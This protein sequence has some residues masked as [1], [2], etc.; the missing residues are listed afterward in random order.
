MRYKGELQIID[1]HSHILP[2]LD[3]G[4]KN[5]EQSKKMLDIA[6][7]QNIH[8]IIATPHFMPEHKNPSKEKVLEKLTK[9]QEYSDRQGYGITL[10]PG[11]EIYYHEEVPDLLEEGKIITLANS[12]YVLVEFSPMDD[13][14]YIR[15]SLA[16][17]QNVGFKPIIAHVERYENICRKPFNKLKEL[18]DMGVM[19][20]V[21]MAS[22]EGKMG[23]KLQK[24]VLSMMKKQ[25]VDLLGTDA[26]SDGSRAPYTCNC[27]AILCR[28]CPADYI[29][30]LFYKN[31]E[32]I[33]QDG[34]KHGTEQQ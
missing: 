7:E 8:K 22:V 9:L 17:I 5:L 34:M 28:K 1:V 23:K 26:H 12:D 33:I 15:N 16:Q 19:I 29:E 25:Y 4:A 14:R 6:A 18:R 2:G 30:K 27:K 21:N 24:S 3:D 11:Q 31:A 13:F 20:Q 32:K 10:L